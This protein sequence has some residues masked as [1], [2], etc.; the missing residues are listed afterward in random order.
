MKITVTGFKG[1]NA[2]TTTAVH[3]AAYFQERAPTLL[4]DGDPNRSATG[5]NERGRLP[6]TILDERDARRH[7]PQYQ[8][9]IVDTQARPSPGELRDLARSCDLL[10]I[11]TTPDALALDALLLT[12]DTLQGIGAKHYRILLTIVPPH[13]SRDGEE[14]RATLKARGLPLFRGEIRRYVAFQ[15]AALLGI[16][17]YQVGGPRA[18][19]AWSDY[20]QIGREI[21]R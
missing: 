3:L 14:A 12:I 16:P 20:Q 4:I 10:I 5:W 11:P 13:P 19:I 18:K 15:K 9:Y 6:F 2:K 17:V 7:T 1:G 8:H 21:A